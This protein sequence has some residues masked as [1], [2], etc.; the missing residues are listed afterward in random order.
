MVIIAPLFRTWLE[1]GSYSTMRSMIP[2]NSR[3]S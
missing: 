2:N 3:K 1:G